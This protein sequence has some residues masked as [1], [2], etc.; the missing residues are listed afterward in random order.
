MWGLHSLSSPA[1]LMTTDSY[2][3]SSWGHQVTTWRTPAQLSPQD[4]HQTSSKK[5][6]FAVLSQRNLVVCNFAMTAAPRL[7]WHVS[8]KGRPFVHPLQHFLCAPLSTYRGLELLTLSTSPPCP[9]I[10]ILGC[11]S[12]LCPPFSLILSVSI[13]SPGSAK[14]QKLDWQKSNS[15]QNKLRL[16][17]KKEIPSGMDKVRCK[18]WKH[19]LENCYP[20]HLLLVPKQ[21]C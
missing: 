14:A 18:D 19:S 4:L 20:Y 2:D 7:S 10:S 9:S 6:T 3:Q 13:E 15:M 5:W 17:G 1:I 11:F 8:V 21:V 16:Q 12:L